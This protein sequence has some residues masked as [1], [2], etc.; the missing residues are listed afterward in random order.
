M[1]YKGSILEDRNHGLCRDSLLR[2]HW[3]MGTTADDRHNS[4]V[5]RQEWRPYTAIIFVG[6]EGLIRWTL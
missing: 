2:V 4:R 1:V 3:T 6:R 5:G